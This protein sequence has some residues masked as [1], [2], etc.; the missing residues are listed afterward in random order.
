MKTYI[1]VTDDDWYAFLSGRPDLDEINFWRPGGNASFRALKPGELF[2]FKLHAPRNYI[3]GG[4]IFGHFSM[5]PV[6][7]AWETFR[8]RN[9]AP[10]LKELRR[11]IARHR[12]AR[13]P[14]DE[15]YSIGCILLEQ[16]F[17]LP[18][19]QWI[20][21]PEDLILYGPGKTYDLTSE[22]GRALLERLREVLKSLP[23]KLTLIAED[24]DLHGEPM[25]VVPRL[26]QG[27][28]RI[29]VIDT[30]QRRCAVTREKVL[31][32]LE[33]AHIKPVSEGGQHQVDNGLLLRSDVHTL[34]DRGYVTVD[35]D[36]Q[37]RVSRRLKADFDN[38]EHYFQ[39]QGKKIWVPSHVRD[40]PNR[41]FLEWHA[42]TVFLG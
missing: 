32:V 4:G 18:R 29:L 14:S 10:D 35:A 31:P 38:G 13:A 28:F 24:T 20:P 41:E 34:F 3:V 21:A 19:G 27:T 39:L 22:S 16:P 5:L 25:L 36:F 7:L 8:E 15:D 12:T 11:R 33:A 37:F 42:D 17:F 1:A 6:S 23:Q 40:Q 2:L 9:G 26:G 30:Y